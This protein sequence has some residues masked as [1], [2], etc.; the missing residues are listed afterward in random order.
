MKKINN[1][2]WMSAIALA[3]AMGFTACSSDDDTMENVNPSFDGKS[4]KTQIAINLPQAK[5]TRQSATVTQNDNAFRGMDGMT[6]I[7]LPQAPQA[8]L[9]FTT[10]SVV[11]L[12]DLG[13]STLS[14][15]QSSKTYNDISIPVGTEHFLFYGEGEALSSSRLTVENK[16]INGVLD[17]N[18]TSID[19]TDDI[20][21]SVQKIDNTTANTVRTQMLTILNAVLGTTGWADQTDGNPLK[22]LYNEF[23]SLKSASPNNVKEVMEDL[24][25]AVAGMAEAPSASTQKTIAT[26]I[27]TNINTNF[28]VTGNLTDGYKITDFEGTTLAS[29]LTNLQTAN[30][31]QGALAIEFS[32]SSFGI[33]SSSTP[34]SNLLLD[35][36][37]YPASLMYYVNTDLRTTDSDNDFEWPTTSSAWTTEGNWEGW[38]GKVLATT[39][40][41]A[42]KKNIEYGVARLATTV[43]CSSSTLEDNAKLLGGATTDASISV[44]ANGF[45]VSA[46]LVGGQ[47]TQ[48]GWEMEPTV[49]DNR[50]AVIYDSKMN[51]TIA[52]KGG[53]YEG[54]NYTMVLDNKKSAD[55]ETINIA[56]ELTNNSGTDFYG[57]QGLIPA[58]AKF[59]LVAQLNPA[60]T[61]GTIGANPLSVGRVFLKDHTTTANLTIKNLKGA[62]LSI[63]DLRSTK[64]QLGL[65]VDLTWQAGLT[66]DVTIQ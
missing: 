61:D 49:D 53:I 64:L 20:T 21:F 12:G 50:T 42:L 6:L 8:G 62:Y 23:K 56:V 18:F 26:A 43:K 10:S 34:T 66:F 4:V 48:V 58:G 15:S 41:I 7:P 55:Q 44:D 47:P 51:G 22:S 1:L 54:T 24:Y 32:G 39:R 65:S 27:C 14:T 37:Y 46:I 57:V 29:Y 35:N 38:T 13:K 16:A 30:I 63:P 9:A 3:G 52:A 33:P 11:D 60:A 31:P 40:K 2:A 25:N 17:Y 36:L 59:Y 45:P 28:V 19:N 5:L